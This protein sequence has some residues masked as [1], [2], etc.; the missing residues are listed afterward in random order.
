MGEELTKLEIGDISKLI[1]AIY[2]TDTDF[3]QILLKSVMGAFK[4]SHQNTNIQYGFG[5]TKPDQHAID[6]L[7]E[8]VFILSDKTTSKLEGDLRF[9][10]IAGLKN[11][12]S[13]SAITKRLDGIF[14]DM[15]PW[16]LERISRTEILNAQNAGRMSAYEKSGAVKY[17]MWQA[18][19]NNARTAADSKRL[20]GQIQK[21]SDPFVDPKTGDTFMH[22]PNRPQCRCTLIPLRKLPD[23]VITTGGMMYAADKK[24]GKIEIN[25]ESLNKKEIPVKG[26]TDKKGRYHKPHTRKVKAKAP[27]EVPKEDISDKKPMVMTPDN[28]KEILSLSDLGMMGGVH[29]QHTHVLK[30]KDNS[31]AIYKDMDEEPIFGEVST[32]EINKLLGWDIV[33]ETVSNDFGRGVGTSQRIIEGGKSPLSPSRPSAGCVRAEEKHFDD[34]AKI[35]VLD[36]ITGNNDRTGGNTIITDDRVHAIDNEFFGYPGMTASSLKVLDELTQ[37]GYSNRNDPTWGDSTP[38]FAWL[39]LLEYDN[40]DI[41]KKLNSLAIKHFRHALDKKSEI[42]NYYSDDKYK[43]VF[44]NDGDTVMS[45]VVEVIEENFIDIEK[46][47]EKYVDKYEDKT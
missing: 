40:P 47:V 7:Q 37:T 9:E 38:M 14:S 31:H 30:L 4:T 10:L 2:I 22:P 43:D 35:L 36:L 5:G 19:I 15:M 13:I 34:I 21:L 8:R 41:Y 18:A 27:G 44:M 24:L 45:D 33:P 3:R 17:K 32:Y 29:H 12:E 16:Q 11:N 46:Y 6:Y 25:T 39:A 1:A 26:F 42:V 20:H 23:D 28:V